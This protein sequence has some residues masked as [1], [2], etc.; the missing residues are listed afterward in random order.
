MTQDEIKTDRVDL[1]TLTKTQIQNKAGRKPTRAPR[2]DEAEQ[3]VVA[4]RKYMAPPG[5]Y[6]EWMEDQK[7]EW[8]KNN[9][10][11]RSR[12]MPGRFEPELEKGEQKE[13][14]TAQMVAEA[15]DI[16]CVLP[17]PDIRPD[18]TW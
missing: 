8:I 18:H 2:Q 6:D 1:I 4:P 10:L 3:G 12:R 11:T 15:D 5:F 7:Q 13:K 9:E 17:Q 14:E 16:R